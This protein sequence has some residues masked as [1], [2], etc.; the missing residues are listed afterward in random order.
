MT[1]P[2]VVTALAAAPAPAPTSEPS[3][4]VPTVITPALVAA[5][6]EVLGASA[7]A[8]V[9]SPCISVCR[10]DRERGWCSGCLRTLEE[11]REWGRADSARKYAVWG[12]IAQRIDNFK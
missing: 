10:M 5:C 4:S 12:L 11:L 3:P 8:L 7:Q 2:P 1:Q 9:P 6:A